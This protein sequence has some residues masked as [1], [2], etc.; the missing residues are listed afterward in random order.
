MAARHAFAALVISLA[1][2]GVSAARADVMISG[3]GTWG[4]ST[5]PTPESAPGESFSYSFDIP[6]PYTGT[7]FGSPAE[8]LET[9]EATNLVYD[10]NGSPVSLH[11]NEVVFFNS[12]YSGM[13]TLLFS[14]G[15]YLGVFGSDIG[16]TGTI[17]TGDFSSVY[18]INANGPPNP[19]QASGEVL[20]GPVTAVVPEPASLA[21]LGTALAGLALFRRRRP[22][23]SF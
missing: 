1:V 7:V 3:S 20:V 21:L 23:Q 22:S 9:T 8:G 17:Q 16:S 13:F 19:S 2:C 14:N 4:A 12:S 5:P 18:G 15:S 6:N 10:L 11:L